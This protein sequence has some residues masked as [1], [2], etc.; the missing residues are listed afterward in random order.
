[1]RQPPL[2]TLARRQ[3]RFAKALLAACHNYCMLVVIPCTGTCSLCSVS[4]RAR[5]ASIRQ[6]LL[7]FRVP[8]LL[9][10]GF[11]SPVQTRLPLEEGA[12][13][14]RGRKRSRER[15]G[16]LARIYRS[17]ALRIT[18]AWRRFGINMYNSKFSGCIDIF[19][20]AHANRLFAIGQRHLVSDVLKNHRL[21]QML[22]VD[23]KFT[24]RGSTQLVGMRRKSQHEVRYG[25]PCR[26]V[27]RQ[28]TQQL[29]I[30]LRNKAEWLQSPCVK[31]AMLPILETAAGN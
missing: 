15:V 11:A 5:G 16:R 18:R 23:C 4:V 31:A 1:M 17:T 14:A 27:T 7:E 25:F 24:C 10:N 30:C 3:S 2:E 26:L 20:Q 12:T 21:F 13:K 29:R 19:G 9:S 8:V 28:N 22:N 6:L